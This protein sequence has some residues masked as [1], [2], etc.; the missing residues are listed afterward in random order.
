MSVLAGRICPSCGVEVPS[1]APVCSSCRANLGDEDGAVGPD[2]TG[3]NGK[4][5]MALLFG[6]AGI[7]ILP[8]VFSLLAVLF[9]ISAKRD[10]RRT[11]GMAGNRRATAGIA[12][13]VVGLALLPVWV[14]YVLSA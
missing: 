7:V 6:A 9:G 1:E 13:G 3:T 5:T 11:P 14:A 10:I 8:M 4:A 2:R 12:L